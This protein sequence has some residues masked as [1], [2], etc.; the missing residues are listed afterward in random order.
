MNLKHLTDKV[1]LADIKVLVAHEREISLKVLHHLKEIER[2]R[3]FADMG[4]GSLFDYA[5]K[6]LKYSEP[7]AARRIQAA[8][9]LKDFPELEKKVSNGSMTIT[10]L[11]LAGL[12]F[13]KENVT[14][15]EVQ[16]DILKKIE[17]TSKRECEKTLLELAPSQPLPKEKEKLITPTIYGVNFNLSAKTMD[18]LRE[19]RDLL[20]HRRLKQDEIVSYAF[21]AA[22]EKIKKEKFKIDANFN[23][24]GAKP[25]T[26]YIPANVKK[27]VYERDQGKCTNCKS[28][29]KIEYDHIQPFSLGGESTLKNLRLLC[30]SCNQRRNKN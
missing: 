11:A 21:Q 7:S 25:C 26:R 15:K 6:E 28:T 30:F 4:Y 12:A 2:R 5:V 16:K 17:K 1:L 23:T 20:A 27:A 19:L 22:I 9:L 10:N 29:H 14:D 8:R 18:E 13:K 24:P 3:L